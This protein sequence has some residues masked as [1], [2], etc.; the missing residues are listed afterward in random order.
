MDWT[1]MTTGERNT[2]RALLK[3]LQGAGVVTTVSQVAKYFDEVQNWSSGLLSLDKL[4]AVAE[5]PAPA[6]SGQE[7][8]LAPLAEEPAAE[9]DAMAEVRSAKDAKTAADARLN[10]ALI[11]AKNAGRSANAIAAAVKGVISRP[12][13]LEILGEASIRDRAIQALKD[14]GFNPTEAVSV[15][16]SKRKT[17]LT[18]NIE[19]PVSTRGNTAAGV[20]DALAKVGLGVAQGESTLNMQTHLGDGEPVEVFELN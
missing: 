17:W 18:L 15:W 8:A 5:W 19:G 12:V 3:D 13:V 6:Q 20:I 1:K 7:T 2:A 4:I 10:A 11:A 14:A 16:T 9:I